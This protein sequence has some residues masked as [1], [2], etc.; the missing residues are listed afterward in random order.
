MRQ[1]I[2]RVRGKKRDSIAEW[3]ARIEK[4]YPVRVGW[5]KLPLHNGYIFSM[6]KYG[7]IHADLHAVLCTWLHMRKSL[8]YMALCT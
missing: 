1:Y 3:Y 5:V 2:A 6:P 4:M 7:S 8:V